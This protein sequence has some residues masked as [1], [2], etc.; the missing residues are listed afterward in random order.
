MSNPSSTPSNKVTVH[1]VDDDQSMRTALCRLLGAAGYATRAYA[2]ADE[3]L[4][5]APQDPACFVLDMMLP[6]RNGLELQAAFANWPTPPQVVFVTGHGN[7]ASTVRA[8]QA[9]AVDVLTKPV[10]REHLVSAVDRALVRSERAGAERRQQQL[11]RERHASLTERETEV[12]EHVVRGAMNKQIAHA[13]DMAKRTVK[14]HRA[15]VMEKMQAGSLAELVRM[16]QQ[17]PPFETA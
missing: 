14:A 12:F 3:V 10:H 1:V 2:S 13:L 16:A 11:W 8:M 6:G 4:Q 5:A 15:Q 7:V 9:G 17:L